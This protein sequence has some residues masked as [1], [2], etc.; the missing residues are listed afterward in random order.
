VVGRR[1]RGKRGRKKHPLEIPNPGEEIGDNF[2]N[3]KGERGGGKK[4][5]LS[6]FVGKR[7]SLIV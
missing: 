5:S 6:S 1:A 3:R 4:G 7:G 2:G